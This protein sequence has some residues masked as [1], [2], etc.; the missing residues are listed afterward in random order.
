MSDNKAYL[1]LLYLEPLVLLL[2]GWS[3]VLALV[4][5]HNVESALSDSKGMLLSAFV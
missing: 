4:L 3:I 5:L 2:L 1:I